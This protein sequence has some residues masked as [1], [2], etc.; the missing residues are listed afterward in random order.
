MTEYIHRS[1]RTWEDFEPD[2]EVRS[3]GDGR[4]VTGIVV[5]FGR[6]ATVSDG[7]PSYKEQ[8]RRGA[9]AQTINV[10]A[11]RVKLLEQHNAARWPLGRATLL[12]EDAA[13]LY[14]EFRIAP[15]D[16]G[17]RAL[18]LLKEGA[19]DSFSVGF[20]PRK[21]ITEKGVT[22][23]TEVHLREVSL[24]TFPAYEDAL[25]SGVRSTLDALSTLTDAQ[26]AELVEAIRLGRTTPDEEQVGTGTPPGAAAPDEQAV[27]HS[28]RNHIAWANFKAALVEEG[29]TK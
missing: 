19:L 25:V 23:R 6:E 10:G 20:S 4:T 12:R 7:G 11:K 15:T 5:P 28:A 3:A 24:V 18:T 16:D 8:F 29:I 26:R 27:D 14:G 17:E 9:F 22:V 2:L 1:T 21:H 13:G